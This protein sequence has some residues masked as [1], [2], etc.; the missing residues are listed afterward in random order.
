[1][2]YR[3]IFL[4]FAKCPSCKRN[5]SVS[6]NKIELPLQPVELSRHKQV[7]AASVGGAKAQGLIHL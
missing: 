1:M 5:M 4:V 3:G 6:K 2:T 7:E